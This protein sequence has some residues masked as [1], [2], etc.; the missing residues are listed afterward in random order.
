MRGASGFELPPLNV[1]VTVPAGTLE[2]AAFSKLPFPFVRHSDQPDRAHRTLRERLFQE[3]AGRGE[4]VCPCTM[5]AENFA[6]LGLP[7]SP[8]FLG[9]DPTL[10]RSFRGHKDAVSS[11]AWNPNLKQLITGSLDCSVMVWNFK[12]ALRAF[13]FSGHKVQLSDTSRAGKLVFLQG[14]SSLPLVSL[15]V[16][17]L[18]VFCRVLCTQLRSR[19]RTGS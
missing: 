10:E 19:P 12:P 4:R 18:P 8:E 9:E 11:V 7:T 16:P 15:S 1:T 17:L 14:C 2:P 3:Q 5:A 6:G 13:R